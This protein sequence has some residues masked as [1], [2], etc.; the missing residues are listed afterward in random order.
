MPREGPIQYTRDHLL[1]VGRPLSIKENP[2]TCA[3]FLNQCPPEFMVGIH[4]E[5]SR[6]RGA[7]PFLE[8]L[9]QVRP[10]VD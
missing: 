9:R 7:L 6:Q 5:I 2:S 10:E 1:M 8:Q 4:K 3:H